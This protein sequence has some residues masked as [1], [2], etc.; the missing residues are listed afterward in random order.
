MRV[1][2]VVCVI[3]ALAIADATKTPAFYYRRDYPELAAQVH[4]D[5]NRFCRRHHRNFNANGTVATPKHGGR[6]SKLPYTVAFHA[7]TIFKAGK[8]VKAFPSADAKRKV[9]VHVWWT[10]IE[11]ACHENDTLHQL[12]SD[13]NIT[14]KRLLKYM[15]KADPNLVRRRIDVK[16]DLTKIQK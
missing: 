2:A 6:P 12:C 13:Y 16:L 8:M 10:S 14:P 5:L 4:Q 3:M 1:A 7:S 15:K 9:D 11:V